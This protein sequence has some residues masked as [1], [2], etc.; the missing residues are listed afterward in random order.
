[1]NHFTKIV[2]FRAGGNVLF[3]TKVCT[4]SYGFACNVFKD[5]CHIGLYLS[6]SSLAYY[7]WLTGL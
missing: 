6:T 3:C 7:I 4:L 5:I 2:S 1:M